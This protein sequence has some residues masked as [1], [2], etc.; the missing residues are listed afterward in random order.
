MYG[1]MFFRRHMALTPAAINPMP[2]AW[3]SVFV[4]MNF[5]FLYKK[6]VVLNNKFTT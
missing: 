3:F 1:E 2:I 5:S 4:D 6:Y